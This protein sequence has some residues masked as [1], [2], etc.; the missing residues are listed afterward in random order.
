MIV[1]FAKDAEFLEGRTVGAL[2]GRVGG[3]ATHPV[4]ICCDYFNSNLY[5]DADFSHVEAL[6]GLRMHTI[7]DRF[8]DEVGMTMSQYLKSQRIK[9]AMHLLHY[10]DYS[11]ADIGYM[12]IQRILDRRRLRAAKHRAGNVK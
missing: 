9:E 2:R 11:L 4:R 12:W 5:S 8:R 6:T 7:C 10:S 1:E 3:G